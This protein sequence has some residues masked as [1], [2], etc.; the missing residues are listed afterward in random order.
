MSIFDENKIDRLTKENSELSILSYDVNSI[1]K[2]IFQSSNIKAIMGASKIIEE[3]DKQVI[4][5]MREFYVVTAIGGTG[6][7]IVPS[8]RERDSK[9][10][11]KALF[12]QNVPGGE[13]T[14]SSVRFKKHELENKIKNDKKYKMLSSIAGVKFENMDGKGSYSDI[15]KI[16][17]SEM[18]RQKSMNVPK[19]PLFADVQRCE[20]CNIMPASQSYNFPDGNLHVCKACA[21]KIEKGKEIIQNKGYA[22]E[23]SEIHFSEMDEDWIG[24]IKIDINNLGNLYS[25]MKSAKDF[26]DKSKQIDQIIEN[27]IKEV[28][29]KHNLTNRYIVPVHGGDDLFIL[30]P[31]SKMIEIFRDLSTNLKKGLYKIELSFSAGI[32]ISNIK[33][34][35]KFIFESAEALI[36][37]A[38]KKAYEGNK[39]M[40]NFVAFKVISSNSID[41]IVEGILYEDDKTK[42]IYNLGF[43][44][45]IDQFFND[46][47]FVED[48]KKEKVIPFLQKT[49][50]CIKD[51]YEIA[52]LN[53]NYFFYRSKMENVIKDPIEYFNTIALFESSKSNGKNTYESKIP[54]LL[55]LSRLWR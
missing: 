28:V 48:M 37:S 16:L 35:I 3:F 21:K 47:K 38:K 29:Q 44:M 22:Q 42:N 26:V 8:D 12:Y 13:I 17:S 10:K 15:F 1:Q 53:V 25:N 34:P 39:K 54:Y 41:P 24:F 51:R 4:D 7:I 45:S 43:G 40:E 52:G 23:L 5:E 30:V 6:M 49:Y 27:G 33:M 19:P 50:T 55:E 11:I 9:E 46:V 20:L 32:G 31:S 2:Y 36:S 18:Q 14:L